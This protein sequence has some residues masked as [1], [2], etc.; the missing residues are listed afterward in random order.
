MHFCLVDWLLIKAKDT[1][2]WLLQYLK[3]VCLLREL[4]NYNE[5]SLIK[6]ENEIKPYIF[7]F[8]LQF[9][10]NIVINQAIFLS[11]FKYWHRFLDN[12]NINNRLFF[13]HHFFS[14]LCMSLSPALRCF[15]TPERLTLLDDSL[16]IWSNAPEVTS[17]QPLKT[18]ITRYSNNRKF[19]TKNAIS[20]DN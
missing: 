5:S 10:K 8:S 7:W 12:K 15:D 2:I 4:K 6:Q 11:F 9:S 14:F 13:S 1:T 20:R 19:E 18:C 17:A 3:W 16:Y